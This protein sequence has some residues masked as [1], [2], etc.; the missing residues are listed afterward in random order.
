METKSSAE[1]KSLPL[2]GLC[3]IAKQEAHVISEMLV[4]VL[5]FINYY[6]FVDTGSTDGTQDI[7]KTIM[8]KHNVPGEIHQYTWD[9][10]KNGRFDFGYN[11]TLAFNLCK[12]KCRYA[13]VMDADDYLI[14]QKTIKSVPKCLISDTDMIQEHDGFQLPTCLVNGSE[15]IAEK[16]MYYPRLHLLRTDR[17]WKYVGAFHEQAVLDVNIS[18]NEEYY[19]KMAA[20]THNRQFG[21]RPILFPDNS[22]VLGLRSI[23]DRSKD[24]D[25]FKNDAVQLHKML[26]RDPI[27]ARY[28]Y[29][30][31][32]AWY[33]SNDFK[34]AKKAYEKFVEMTDKVHDKLVN[35]NFGYNARRQLGLCAI[36][37]GQSALEIIECYKRAWNFDKR[38]A[39]PASQIMQLCNNSS[40]AY[41]HVSCMISS[42]SYSP[43]LLLCDKRLYNWQVYFQYIH[44]C[45]SAKKYKEAIQQICLLLKGQK[46]IDEGPKF[47]EQFQSQLKKLMA[48]CLEK[49]KIENNM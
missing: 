22:L 49:Q 28:A 45:I 30:E 5:P 16:P 10:E 17:P 42:I 29:Y 39:E 36:A 23:G 46:Y 13:F 8:D 32:Q 6:I 43:S 11:R 40:T 21:N 19:H 1:W 9:S 33:G 37:L 27:N 48:D 41:D 14:I 31:G 3:F 4:S 35:Y 7:V 2:V 26:E 20:M 25:K 38:R 34:K 12:T 44:V 15:G 47:V 18:K 24:K